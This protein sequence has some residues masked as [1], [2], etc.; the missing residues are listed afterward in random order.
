MHVRFSGLGHPR[1][2]RWGENAGRPGDA[3]AG[4]WPIHGL[5]SCGGEDISIRNQRPAG[6]LG[7]G[8]IGRATHSPV[9]LP[10]GARLT[11][12]QD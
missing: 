3:Y 8:R 4:L 2:Q 10:A 1:L 11:L 7:D 12:N 6:G 9:G 5:A